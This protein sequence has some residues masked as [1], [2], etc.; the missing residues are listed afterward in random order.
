M[1]EQDDRDTCGGTTGIMSM[2]LAGGAH[3][4]TTVTEG[5]LW[6]DGVWK[7]QKTRPHLIAV[8]VSCVPFVYA[9]TTPA[10][11]EITRKIHLGSEYVISTP[12]LEMFNNKQYLEPQN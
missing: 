3:L 2:P 5:R 10:L 9:N 7:I 4:Q 12:A 8:E 6:Y 1:M 11:M